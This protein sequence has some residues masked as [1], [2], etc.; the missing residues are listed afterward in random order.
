MRFPDRNRGAGTMN[1]PAFFEAGDV[2]ADDFARRAA[3]RG[4]DVMDIR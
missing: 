2:P 1:R 3:H 4:G